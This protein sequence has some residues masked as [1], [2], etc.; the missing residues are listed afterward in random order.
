MK[1]V[2]DLLEQVSDLTLNRTG[3][4]AH[5]LFDFSN[6]HGGIS[7]METIRQYPPELLSILGETNISD[8]AGKTLMRHIVDGQASAGSD[9]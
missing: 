4:T 9:G 6:V 1:E 8:P 3:H 2:N 5:P 7:L